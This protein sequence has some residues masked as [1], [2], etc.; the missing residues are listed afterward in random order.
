MLF[1]ALRNLRARPA[2]TLFTAFAIALGVALIFAG[3]IVGVATDE[4][5]RQA[6]ESRLAG[7]DLE[8]SSATRVNFSAR[9]ADEL[10]ER[11]EVESTAPLLRA[12]VEGSDLN[13]LGVDVA[14]PLRPHEIVA[15]VFFS[16][17]EA[18]EILIPLGWAAQHGL[19]VGNEVELTLLGQTRAFTVIGL[20]KEEGLPSGAPVAWVPI[21]TL[22]A[23]LAAPDETT[24]ILVK[25]KPNTP[26]TAARESLQ[27][28]LGTAYVVSSVET[29]V[30]DGDVIQQAL[31]GAAMPFAG[32]VILLAGA[33]FIYNAFAI[34][35][36][37]RTRE[38]G[39]LRAL[40]MTRG[41][42]LALTLTEAG[43]VSLAG[44]LVGLLIGY[45]LGAFI[46]TQS[47]ASNVGV[48]VD[49]VLLAV[50]MGVVVT[51]GVVFNLA[52]QAGR[53]SPLVALRVETVN[54]PVARRAWW[55]ALGA[56]ACLALFAFI[57]WRML[58]HWKTATNSMSW[59]T[60][61]PPLILGG[62]VLF[63][64]PLFTRALLRLGARLR[65][66]VSGRL[67]LDTLSRQPGRAALTTVTLT[68]SLMLVIFLTAITQGIAASFAESYTPLFADYDFGLVRST[69][70][71]EVGPPL[72]PALQT[73]LEALAARAAMFGF[74]SIPVADPNSY[75]F[76]V[77]APAPVYVGDLAFF[78]R[79]RL[80]RAME[81]SWEEAETYFAAGPAIAVSEV[82]ARVYNVHPGDKLPIDTYEGPVDFTVAVVSNAFIFTKADGARYFHVHPTLF[83]FSIPPGADSDSIRAQARDLATKHKLQFLDEPNTFFSSFLDIFLGG[84]LA[85]F[86]GLTSISGVV[87]ALGIANTLIASVLERQRELGTLRALGFTRG[88]VRGLVVIEAGLLGFIGSLLGVVG[89]LAMGYA[90]QQLINAQFATVGFEAPSG[91]PLPWGVA[92]FALMA[93][94]GLAMLVALWPADRAANVN[95]AD[96]MRAEG[97]TGFLKP[98]S[99]L[100]P[101]GLRGLLA[102]LPLAAKLSFTTGLIIIVT[103][104]ALTAVR[105]NY[106]RQLIEDNIRA[107]FA[108]AA[109]LTVNASESQIPADVTELTP[110]LVQTMTEQSGAS[111]D[112]LN[113]LFQ[114]GNSPYDFKL[115]Y[116]FI[117]DSQHKVL[118]G[119]RAEY[120]NTT[121]TNTVALAGSAST[122]RLTDWIGERAFESVVAIQNQGGQMLGYLILGLSTDPVDNITRD[123]V[124]SSLWMMAVALAVAVALTV[125]FTRRAL[126]PLAHIADASHAVA[127]GDLSQRIPETRWDEVGRLSRSFNDM[128]KGLN[129]RERIRDLFGRYV[130][131]EVQ[132][133]VLAGRVTLAGARK[134]ITCLY[135][136]MR[137]STTFAEKYQP[138]EVVSALNGYFEVIILATEAHGGIVN[139]FVGDEAVCVFGA[140][141][142]Y[143]DHADRA[144]QAA[145]AMREGLA[146]LN[147][148]RE[149]LGLPT[150]KFGMGLNSGEVVAGATGSEERQEYTVIGDAMNVGARIQA[151]NKTF[152]DYDILLSEFTVAAL[153]N[154]YALVDLGPVELRGKSEMV[155]VFGIADL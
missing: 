57:Y 129:E 79:A 49:G 35:L 19:G 148:K 29:G 94:P 59:D 43:L 123:I 96:A 23:A 103:I 110:A 114:G 136:D 84:I 69:T 76:G 25:L 104:A 78:N 17:P 81:G 116:A 106:E 8:I 7:A 132:H 150:L 137:G 21:A 138:E 39:Q 9:I 61:T 44:S 143:R 135:V 95:P 58:N 15:G 113:Q 75:P 147:R 107:I 52:W 41:Q 10:L 26:T 72:P 108:R 47:G 139:R 89:G 125:F 149:A 127:R 112:S 27:D 74:G 16:A 140:P 130:S 105:V 142:D 34:T 37:E 119:T 83:F 87:A 68:I 145:L 152:P 117:T 122:V 124:Q 31:T 151:L 88:Q 134:T 3:R 93:G 4:L 141:R 66:G 77:T 67:A 65:W 115:K 131:H 97:A 100:G 92:I 86:G 14:Q 73:D 48:P 54:R 12:R 85:L 55:S 118:S 99:H 28:A 45:S 120:N 24:T 70:S 144:L 63:A 64:L 154:N 80:F 98:A 50:G 33:F 133:E 11:P 42:V 128:V 20:L 51:M 90:A 71:N 153:K 6:R 32:V 18:H 101:T 30:I 146:Y 53:V 109:E 62:A 102:R 126:A 121:L 13:L 82:A 56:V 38:I 91:L 2:R 5:N 60:F 155:R 1:L 36:A 22:Q 46:A 40:G 111:A